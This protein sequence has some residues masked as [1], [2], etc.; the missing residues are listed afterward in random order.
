[1]WGLLAVV[2]AFFLGWKWGKR[3]KPAPPVALTE[4]EK[5]ALAD[6]EK[7]MRYDGFTD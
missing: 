4:A 7:F 3:R 1:M 2:P 5:R 6:F